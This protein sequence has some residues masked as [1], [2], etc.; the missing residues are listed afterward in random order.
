MTAQPAKIA[1]YPGMFDPVHLGHVDVIRRAS[2][3]F[4]RLVVG[5]GVNPTKEPLFTADERVT[6]L[7]QVV[8]SLP[9]VDVQPFGTLAVRFAKD[10]GADVMIRGL[11]TVSD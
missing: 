9:N 8:A 5:V 2:Q 7:K 3:L 11:R 10:Q 6:M 1:V 4:P